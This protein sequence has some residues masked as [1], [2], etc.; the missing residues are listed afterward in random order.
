MFVVNPEMDAK[1]YFLL[2]ELIREHDYRY[3]T[4]DTPSITDAEYDRLVLELQD[5]EKRYPH[6]ISPDSPTQRVGSSPVR[7]LATVTHRM[8]MLSLTNAFEEEEVIAFVQRLEEKLDT[9]P[10]E[11]SVEPKIDGL[12]VSLCYE[13]GIFKQAATR[14]DGVTGEDVTHALRTIKSVPMRLHGTEHPPLVEV[15]G[16]VFMHR[17]TFEALNAAAHKQGGKIFANPR[18]AAA[19]SLRQLDPKV[20]ASRSL[21]FF[22]YSVGVVEG[23]EL[24]LLHSQMLKLMQSWG[25]PVC[26]EI[27][28][29]SGASGCLEYFRRIG[30][31]RENL[32]YDIDG[33]VYKVN[34]YDY[35]A[36]LGFVSRAPRW[37]I[38]HKYPAQEAQTQIET[39][40]IQVGRT[41]AATPVAR[42]RPVVVA[43]VTVTNATLHNEDQIKRLDVRVGDTVIVRRAGD[44]IPE[45]VRVIQEHRPAQSHIWQMPSSCPICGSYLVRDLGEIVWRCSGDLYCPAQVKERIKHF[46]SRRAMD[47]EGLGDRIIEGLVDFEIIRSVADLYALSLNDFVRLKQL[48]DSRE[49]RE[50]SGGRKAPTKWAENLLR[51]IEVSKTC[52]LERFLYALG[53]REVGEATAKTLAKWFGSL[54]ALASASEAELIMVPDVGPVAASRIVQFFSEHHNAQVIASLRDRGVFW[55]DSLPQRQSSGPLVGQVVVLT[56]TLLS[57][58]REQAKQRLEALGARVSGSISKKTDWI[59]AGT[60]AGSK[61]EKAN[62]LGIK[63][64]DEAEFIALLAQ[65]GEVI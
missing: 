4:Q 40:E 49:G 33:V 30:Q 5:L 3:H 65:H 27:D 17:A 32:P 31:G 45:I 18:N 9:R 26:P 64:I 1:R 55:Q 22:A 54:E 7:E 2:C 58:N 38:A 25:I 16:E 14:G 21:A 57:M 24:P 35:Q 63:V 50:P 11:F 42:L 34:R 59:L 62:A 60:D 51:A 29:A 37:A 61:L 46:A 41:G 53:I 48:T 12:A 10:I 44:V 8:P 20:T 15:R 23:S 19:G 6:L 47:V 28:T 13:N 43:G 56:G 36:Q 39:I 52:T